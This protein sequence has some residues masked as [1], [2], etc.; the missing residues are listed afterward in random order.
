[1]GF[2]DFKPSYPCPDAN[3]MARMKQNPNPKILTV[4]VAIGKRRHTVSADIYAPGDEKN[5]VS[6]PESLVKIVN[7]INS[8]ADK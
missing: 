8:I 4:T 1:M 2:F 6:Y 5:W 7:A 3:C